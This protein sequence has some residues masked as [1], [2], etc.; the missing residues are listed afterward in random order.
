MVHWWPQLQDNCPHGTFLPISRP[1]LGAC[2]KHQLQVRKSSPG[3]ISDAPFLLLRGFAKFRLFAMFP[4]LLTILIMWALC[5][6][7]TQVL[8]NKWQG[9]SRQC[10]WS[11]RWWMS[12]GPIKT[13]TATKTMT[14]LIM[15][16][17]HCQGGGWLAS[18]NPDG[19]GKAGLA[20]ENR[21]VQASL[22]LSVSFTTQHWSPILSNHP[23][24]KMETRIMCTSYSTQGEKRASIRKLTITWGIGSFQPLCFAKAQIPSSVGVANRVSWRS[25]GHDGWSSGELRSGVMIIAII[26]VHFR[27]K[28]CCSFYCGLG[29][30]KIP[31]KAQRIQ[32]QKNWSLK[33]WMGA[34]HSTSIHHPLLT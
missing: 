16:I 30:T 6:I 14:V 13:R 8:I 21:M 34:R 19:W 12:D 29:S 22:P 17:F 1:R 25:L 3:E 28:K 27:R 7:L 11:P 33:P 24:T 15:L 9:W 26:V 18:G 2:A 5:A 32:C 10:W 20:R 23:C 4:V 31:C